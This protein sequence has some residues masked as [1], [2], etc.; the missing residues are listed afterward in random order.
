MMAGV[1]LT[2]LLA[3]AAVQQAHAAPWVP[4]WVSVSALD[5]IQ[6]LVQQRQQRKLRSTATI[7]AVAAAVPSEQL[8]VAPLRRQLLETAEA[9]SYGGYGYGY[10]EY[11]YGY[12]GYA[13]GDSEPAIELS[14]Q[15]MA[16]A[17]QPNFAPTL[18][19]P[20]PSGSSSNGRRL[21]Q[22]IEAGLSHAQ[23]IE[24]S[25]VAAAAVVPTVSFELPSE[26]RAARKL[27]LSASKISVDAL[28][29]AVAPVAPVMIE[30]DDAL[31]SSGS[32]SLLSMGEGS[33]GGSYGGY[34]EYGYGGY[35]YGGYGD[36]EADMTMPASGRALL[37]AAEDDDVSLY[38]VWL[39][40]HQAQHAR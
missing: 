2:V 28:D 12:G 10:G 37:E 34:G 33:Y 22:V 32:R 18:V 21:S 27:L 9:G 23:G 38:Q 11:G 3:T 14:S 31:L 30:V 29:A 8:A 16:A 25:D 6:R 15:D 19:Y 35:G 39:A 5:N 26:R 7:S 17:M 20:E 24:L 36:A 4:D 1:V 13:D 40:N